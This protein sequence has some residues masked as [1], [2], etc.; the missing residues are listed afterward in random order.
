MIISCSNFLLRPWREGDEFSLAEHANNRKIWLNVRDRFPH[1]YSFDNAVQWI[2]KAKHSKT[3]FAI[4]YEGN[5]VGAIGL[6]LK[7]DVHRHSA[8][9][10]Y[11]LGERYW[12]KKIMS[13]AV[14]AIT[15]YAFSNFDVCRVYA[16]LFE[17]N[18]ASA[19]VLEKNGYTLEARLQK[20]I[21]KEGTTYD[22]LM[23]AKIK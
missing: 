4:E 9:I 3:D 19:K 2:Q 13:E 7:E 23:Y 22:E 12:N 17:Y 1:P 20:A 10:G 14:R 15:E 8:E 18:D 21:S 5:A 16:G 11:W 6:I